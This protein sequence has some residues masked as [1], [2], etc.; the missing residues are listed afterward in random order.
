VSPRDERERVPFGLLIHSS[1]IGTKTHRKGSGKQEA[2]AFSLM[3]VLS[4]G[5]DTSLATAPW[6]VASLEAGSAPAIQAHS[7]GTLQSRRDV[8]VAAAVRG[9]TRRLKLHEVAGRD[10]VAI[11]GRRIANVGVIVF[12]SGNLNS[13][14]VA[15]REVQFDRPEHWPEYVS[16]KWLS[17]RAALSLY[18]RKPQA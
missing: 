14:A 8:R 6:I 1:G 16:L 3:S 15:S 4:S 9:W 17:T 7:W 12:A 13:P 5:A 2:G 11:A 18:C 10:R